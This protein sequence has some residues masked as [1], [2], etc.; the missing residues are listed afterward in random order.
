MRT[1]KKLRLKRIFGGDGRAVVVAADHGLMLGPIRGVVNLRETLT[2]VIQGGPDAILLT[3]GQASSLIDLFYGRDAPAL[4][5]RADWTNAFRDKTYTLPARVVRDVNT[6]RVEDASALGASGIVVYL[7]MGLGDED[8]EARNIETVS[9]FSREC[10]KQGMPLIVEP[11]PMGERVT[12]AN[13]VDLV[14]LSVRIAA[15]L[16]AD[17]LKVPYTGDPYTF[18]K[19]VK[20]TDGIPVLALGGYSG[21]TV[22]DSL[23]VVEE[24]MQAGGSGIVYGRN[25]VQAQDPGEMVRLVKAVVHEGRSVLEVVGAS[26]KGRISLTVDPAACVGCNL[27]AAVCSLYHDGKINIG[28]ARL[29]II[30]EWPSGAKPVICVQC[31]KCISVCPAGALKWGLKGN[32]ELVDGLCTSCM[33]CVETCPQKVIRFDE[34]R[35][36]PLV[37][38]LCGGVP[39]C[40]EWCGTAA[41]RVVEKGV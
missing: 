37:C 30:Q 8:E 11:L 4:L 27:C 38:D 36:V 1:G 6:V 28:R 20:A 19:I 40:S 32:V 12:K 13:Y 18:E 31:G 41:I 23:E 24:V 35:S 10:E 3:P 21:V 26:K 15:E 17:A 14:A 25:I 34:E 33:A 5:V 9:R 7:F 22:R 16:G 39:Q 29:R 2:R